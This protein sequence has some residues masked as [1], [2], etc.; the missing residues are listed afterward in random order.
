M[1][2]TSESRAGLLSSVLAS[3][4]LVGY[5]REK[6]S[7]RSSALSADG[8]W[9]ANADSDGLVVL[10]RR[11]SG[12]RRTLS[13]DPRRPATALSLSATGRELAVGDSRG[14]IR[15]YSVAGQ[16]LA[17]LPGAGVSTSAVSAV[18]VTTSPRT[19]AAW[20]DE[21]GRV[22]LAY[23]MDGSRPRRI[24]AGQTGL[25]ALSFSADGREL[26]VGDYSGSVK[27]VANTTA[28]A[29]R[30]AE[31]TGRL[32]RSVLIGLCAI[33][34]SCRGWKPRRQYIHVGHALQR[35]ACV[36]GAR[37]ARTAR[38][39]CR[40]RRRSPC[41]DRSAR[42]GFGM[43]HPAPGAGHRSH[44]GAVEQSRHHSD[45]RAFVVAAAG[46]TI[47]TW[48]LRQQSRV[49]ELLATPGREL[50]DAARS[51]LLA[52]ADQGRYLYWRNGDAVL[53]GT[54]RPER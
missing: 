44:A 48:D 53:P 41:R 9:L 52:A 38:Q 49:S 24:E 10:T 46:G 3:P 4:H 43:G 22:F 27:S 50:P 17:D 15:A 28:V 23:G 47:V 7:V 39:D 42:S 40:R 37:Y 45:N 29:S 54:T 25:T 8:K 33:P 51:G 2:P 14:G 36:S 32:R 11:T 20:T 31:F 13:I 16:Q 6:E 21:S 12:E 18:A 34:V 19:A 5:V 26:A 35:R 1:S 30:A